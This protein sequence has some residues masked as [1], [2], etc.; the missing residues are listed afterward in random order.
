MKSGTRLRS[1]VCDT[2]VMVVRP[3]DGE[4]DLTCGGHPLVAMDAG[5]AT[6]EPADGLDGGTQL[7]KRY[8]DADGTLELL[9]TKAGRGTL[10]LGSTPLE[11][12]GAKP[13]PASD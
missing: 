10:G 13:L 12:K 3:G 9:V 11:I 2:E 8:T 5:P 4:P 6:L 1:Q 7:G